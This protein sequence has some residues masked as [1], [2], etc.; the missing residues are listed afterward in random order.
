MGLL[1]FGP[2]HVSCQHYFYKTCIRLLEPACQISG[3]K[4]ALFYLSLNWIV[5]EMVGDF[6]LGNA[7]FSPRES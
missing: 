7:P 1:H 3:E 4:Y 5:V 6:R 2:L